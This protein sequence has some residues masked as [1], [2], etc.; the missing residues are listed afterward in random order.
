M[1]KHKA[2][3]QLEELYAQLPSVDCQRHCNVGCT[4]ITMSQAEWRRMTKAAGSELRMGPPPT[5]RC[6]V[7]TEDGA[8]GQ[9]EAR[10]MICRLFGVVEG[11]LC[12]WGCKPERVLT[13]QEGF[14]FLRKA[15]LIIP[16]PMKAS[17][18]VPRPP[19]VIG[20]A[21]VNVLGPAEEE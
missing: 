4:G 12:P 17:G 13:T 3:R 15:Q 16:G 7:L 18:R 11:L 5:Y 9:Y 2:D 20:S 10:P 8:C 6:S 1:K 14:A 21:I 19:G